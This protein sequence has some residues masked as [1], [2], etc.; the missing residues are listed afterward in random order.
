MI[1]FDCDSGPQVKRT[2][3]R[4]AM[5]MHEALFGDYPIPDDTSR[6]AHA[7]FPKGNLYLQI[8]DRFGLLYQN[9]QF[10]HLF[11]AEGRPALAPARLA[12]VTVLQFIEGVSDRQA[13]DNVRDR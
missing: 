10:A 4:C 1:V 8:R 6:V 3:G 12:L 13:A 5:S 7:A 2:T 9:N 11:T